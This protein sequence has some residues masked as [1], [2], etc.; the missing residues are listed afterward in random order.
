M[1]R[2]QGTVQEVCFGIGCIAAATVAL[3]GCSQ[4]SQPPT[5]NNSTPMESSQRDMAVVVISAQRVA[6]Q[7]TG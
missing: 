1:I 4:T 6:S 7:P 2:A 5:L 3:L